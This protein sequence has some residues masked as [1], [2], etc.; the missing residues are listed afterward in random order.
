MV[1]VLL[2]IF[3]L[4]SSDYSRRY[5]SKVEVDIRIVGSD[6]YRFFPEKVDGSPSCFHIQGFFIYF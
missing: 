6:R 1:F 3:Q 2:F 4:A 5:F